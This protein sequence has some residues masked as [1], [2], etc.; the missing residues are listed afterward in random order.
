MLKSHRSADK[1]K[2][3]KFSEND[4]R[5]VF[6]KAESLKALIEPEYYGTENIQPYCTN[7]I[8]QTS[9]ANSGRAIR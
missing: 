6:E 3:I 4:L 1:F 9:I 2:N 7:Q 8:K 5:R